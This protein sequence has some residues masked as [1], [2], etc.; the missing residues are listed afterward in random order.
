MNPIANVLVAVFGALGGLAGL[1]ALL[2]VRG[3]RRKL[4]SESHNIDA[5]AATKLSAAS[6]TLLRPAQEEI[7]RLSRKLS[8]AVSQIDALQAEVNSLR[9]Q[10]S[11]MTKDLADSHDEIRRLTGDD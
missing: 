8:D 3:Q 11:T 6:L 1:G 9:G 5:D 2:T 7:D 4:L 10:V